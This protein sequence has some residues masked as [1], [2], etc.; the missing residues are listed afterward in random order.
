MPNKHHLEILK[1]GATKW[2]VWRKKK[3]SGSV[4]PE[5]EEANLAGAD[6]RHY[7]FVNADLMNADLHGALLGGAYMAHAYLEGAD[8]SDANLVDANLSH[9]ELVNTR[10]NSAELSHAL[11]IESNMKGADLQSTR[12]LAS[13]FSRADLKEANFKSAIF[14]STILGDTNLS[15]AFGLNAC[16]H[17]GPSIIDTATLSR[18]GVLP[19]KFLRGCGVPDIFIEF[20]PSLINEPINLY[21]CFISYS[22]KDQVFARRLHSDLQDLGVRCWFAPEDMKIGDKT[23]MRIDDSIRVYDKLLVIL[24]KHSL[25]SDWVEKEVETAMEKERIRKKLVL[26]PIRLDDAVMKIESGWGA[27]IRRAR[28]I[29]DFKTWRDPDSY[30]NA[31]E[32]L[33]RDLSTES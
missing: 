10:F 2:N 9:S 11:F 3:G 33:V 1:Q 31:L 21:S 29:G 25:Q 22:A 19:I 30:Q 4:F 24:S 26:F 15:G 17:D 27:D 32:R 20:L 14:K 18:S 23:R 8:L 7:N 6:L 12:L 28:N 13:D 5:L 16:Q